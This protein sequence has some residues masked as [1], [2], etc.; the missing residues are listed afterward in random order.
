MADAVAS[1]LQAIGLLKCRKFAAPH[2]Y[3]PRTLT[4]MPAH[5]RFLQ[6]LQFLT[7]D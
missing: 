7:R 5:S 1:M 4:Y 2:P 6:R 3:S